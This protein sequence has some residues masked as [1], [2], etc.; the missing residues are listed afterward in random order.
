MEYIFLSLGKS[1]D[2]RKINKKEKPLRYFG[3]GC[4]ENP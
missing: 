1:I 3:K 4:G 2:K